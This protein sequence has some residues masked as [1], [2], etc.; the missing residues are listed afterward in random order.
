MDFVRG[1]KAKLQDLTPS[2]QIE[3]AVNVAPAAGQTIDLSCFGLDANGKLS[4]DRYFVFYNQKSSPCGGLAAAGPQGGSQEVFRIDLA[5]LPATIK[6]MVFIATLDGTGTMATLGVSHLKICAGGQTCASYTFSGSDFK[7]EKAVMIAEIYHK[8]VWRFAA[9]GQGFNGGL[10]AL[11]AHF[12]GQEIG[13]DATPKPVQP[14]PLPPA[15]APRPSA[16]PTPA[17]PP[18]KVNLGKVSLDKRGS[19]VPVDLKKSGGVQPI[20]INLNWDQPQAKRGFLSSLVS[21]SE[22]VDLDL[23]CMFRL[24]TGEKGVIQPLGGNFGARNASPFIHLDKDDRSGAASDGENMYVF[25]PDLIDLVV[26]FAMIYAGAANFSTVNGRL[27][28]RDDSGSEVLIPLNSPDPGKPFC[29]VATIKR[30]GGAIR[31]TKEERYY[32]GHPDC[33]RDFGFGFRWVAGGKD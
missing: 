28:I 3:V 8:D 22:S 32:T 19:S 7:E 2:R 20:H 6:R 17:P 27:T 33:D 30:E 11:V 4:D 25:R 13:P 16:P 21:S 1:Q 10:S 5:R 29:A 24:S 12:G 31:I 26:V 18:P 23:G 9:N 14:P 15:P